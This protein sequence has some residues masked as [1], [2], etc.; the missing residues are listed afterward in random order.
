[1]TGKRSAE[2]TVRDIV[3]SPGVIIL[4]KR[5]FVL[6]WRAFQVRTVLLN[7]ALAKASTAMS[8]TAGRRS[9]LRQ[10]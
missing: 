9:F 8:I 4:P 2:K 3:E 10:A 7:C 6:Y 1:M 5:R